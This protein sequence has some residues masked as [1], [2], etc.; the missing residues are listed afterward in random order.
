MIGNNQKKQSINLGLNPL[1]QNRMMEYY[2]DT[3]KNKLAQKEGF[4]G[5]VV[6]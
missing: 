1:W 2:L 5:R 6:R 4:A 3:K